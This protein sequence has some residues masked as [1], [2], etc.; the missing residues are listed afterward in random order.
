LRRWALRDLNLA[1]RA[2]FEEMAALPGNDFGLVTT[3]VKTLNRVGKKPTHYFQ[4]LTL[5]Y[6]TNLHSY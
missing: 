1:S 5:P 3:P 6:F 4:S 2:C